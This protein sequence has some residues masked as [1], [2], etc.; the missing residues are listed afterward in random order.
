MLLITE[1]TIFVRIKHSYN[2]VPDGMCMRAKLLQLCLDLC[3]PV[4][5][6]LPGSSIHGIFQTRILEWVAMPFSRE[7]S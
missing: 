5:Y 6:S 1:L 2:T 7:S 3:D 4:D